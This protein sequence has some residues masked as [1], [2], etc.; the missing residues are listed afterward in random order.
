MKLLR[1]KPVTTLEGLLERMNI[2][3]GSNKIA[4]VLHHLLSPT[5]TWV[6]EVYEHRHMTTSD[7]S[8]D[9]LEAVFIEAREHGYIIG[10]PLWGSRST[11][12]FVITPQGTNKYNQLKD[13][14]FAKEKTQM[15][16]EP[17]K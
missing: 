1:E 8:T 12:E 2:G 14:R 5:Q 13:E 17:Q 6:C 11:S 10:K 3:W 16:S 15:E 9:V 7:D 4:A